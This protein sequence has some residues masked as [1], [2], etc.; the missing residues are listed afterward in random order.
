MKKCITLLLILV[1]S[2]TN[3]QTF[4]KPASIGI[5]Y[6]YTDFETVT[7]IKSSSFNNVLKNN[8]W[9][10]PAEMMTGLGIDFLKGI[11]H[12]IDFAAS[13]NYTKGINAYNLPSTN[14]ASFSLFTMD[15]LI[16]WK[17]F[18]DKYYVRPYMSTGLGVYIQNGTG[19]YA[20]L[21]VGLQFNIFN[22]AILNL[23]SQYRLPFKNG[24]NSNLYYQL[25][26]ATSIVKKKTVAAKIEAP[27]VK[28]IVV[29][30]P[31]I[32]APIVTAP[33]VEINQRIKDIQ[34]LVVDEETL[35]PLPMVQ[36]SL[37]SA[38]IPTLQTAITDQKGQA[39]F[40]KVKSANYTITGTLNQ[41]NTTTDSI[42]T[43]HFNADTNPITIKLRHRD[44]RFTLVGQA[45]DKSTSLP[46]GA[47]IIT[48]VNN[49]KGITSATNSL[50]KEGSF[51]IQ[52]AAGSDF[53][54][55]G[56]KNGFLSN[57]EKISTKNLTRS[58]TLYVQL[59]LDIQETQLGKSIILN[60]IYFETG[61]SDVN[62]QTSAD[63]DKLVLFLNDNPTIQLEVSGHTDH[64]GTEAKNKILSLS[65]AKSIVDYLIKNK[66]DPAR[67]RSLGFGSTKPIASNSNEA[68]RLQNRR[69]E[70]KRI[71]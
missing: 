53:T 35:S 58:T 28:P 6:S 19:M 22:A 55:T 56:K 25:G 71:Q 5:H 64:I 11:T 63:L 49:T 1:A 50:E 21:G 7:K 40:P 30:A 31:I 33:I 44:P 43:M 36:I 10:I 12:H 37:Q 34:V 62:T 57:I 42:G 13:L 59:A 29:A 9:A 54:V 14:L 20:P 70:I 69:V 51:N 17:L 52:L 32:S 2:C 61:K 3:A 66:I 41:L 46:V 67:L 26:F 8:Q 39:V 68:G 48:V 27:I 65:R 60:K 47:A 23:Q 45:I 24:D 4:I 16:N 15:G 18:S 38:T